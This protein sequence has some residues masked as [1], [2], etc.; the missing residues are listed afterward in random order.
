[1]IYEPWIP[2]AYRL[3]SEIFVG[4]FCIVVA[5]VAAGLIF[6]LV[7]FLLVATRAAQIYV[8]TNEPPKTIA[9][10]AEPPATNSDYPTSVAPGPSAPEP[11]S[12]A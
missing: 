7:R 6:L 9:R 3:V 5:I 11:P 12:V 2:G 4:L 1:M 8:A 10:S